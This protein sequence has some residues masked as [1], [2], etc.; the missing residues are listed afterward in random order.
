MGSYNTCLLT[1]GS[2]GNFKL[3]GINGQTLASVNGEIAT[4]YSNHDS[5]I[6]SLV[7]IEKNLVRS[8]SCLLCLATQDWDHFIHPN[9]SII[10]S[11]SYYS[12]LISN[13]TSLLTSLNTSSSTL[14]QYMLTFLSKNIN[15]TKCQTLYNNYTTRIGNSGICVGGLTCEGFA[16][17]YFGQY[18][19]PGVL[20]KLNRIYLNRSDAVAM[21]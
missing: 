3:P 14:Q 7:E 13:Y 15:Q 20:W 16:K 5:K 18:L 12:T 21:Y 17:K 4:A 19:I 6:Q 10:Y 8:Q 9:A 2:L 1:N 11:T